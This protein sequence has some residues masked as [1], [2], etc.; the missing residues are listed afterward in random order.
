MKKLQVI[1]FITFFLFSLFL[2]SFL[3]MYEYINHPLLI[4]FLIFTMMYTNFYF[5]LKLFDDI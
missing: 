2:L 1:R 5:F 3:I 4:I